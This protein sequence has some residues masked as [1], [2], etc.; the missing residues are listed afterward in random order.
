MCASIILQ[1]RE[2]KEI[3]MATHFA[4]IS[5]LTLRDQADL[6]FGLA[7]GLAIT[8]AEAPRMLAGQFALAYKRNVRQHRVNLIAAINKLV[9]DAK[10]TDQHIEIMVSMTTEIVSADL[11]SLTRIIDNS[12]KIA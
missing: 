4:H 2:T 5:P 1:Q 10:L 6:V 11:V 8:T 7:Q 3:E 12:Q 9:L